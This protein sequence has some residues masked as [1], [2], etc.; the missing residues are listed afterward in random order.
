MTKRAAP[1]TG[2]DLPAKRARESNVEAQVP[3]PMSEMS[4]SKGDSVPTPGTIPLAE[5][6]EPSTDNP[7]A[8]PATS[9]TTPPPEGQVA[10]QD[11]TV[12]TEHPGQAYIDV[13]TVM[14]FDAT[15]LNSMDTAM[16]KTMVLSLTRKAAAVSAT[17]P[18]PV[19]NDSVP[20]SGQPTAATDKTVNVA[21]TSPAI[22][23][24]E[25]A[26]ISKTTGTENESASDKASVT[27]SLVALGVQAHRISRWSVKE[28]KRLHTLLLYADTNRNTFC[29]THTPNEKDWGVPAAFNDPSNALCKAGTST[30]LNLWVVGEIASMWW[31]N[32]EGYPAPHP[33]ISIQP[34]ADGTPDY[35]KTFL[36]ELCMPPHSSTSAESF[37][38]SQV[39]ASCW[40]N[41]KA[42]ANTPS[43]AFEFKAI[44]DARAALRHKKLL[45][46]LN[47]GQLKVRDFVVLEVNVTRYATKAEGEGDK[48]GKRR[49]MDR[50]QTYFDL[51]AV[52]KIKDALP[53]ET[54]VD[55]A[56]DFEI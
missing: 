34:M 33:G 38:A 32:N 15:T 36:H 16:L 47:V 18:A 7:L 31:Y 43:K 27:A 14:G 20:A 50:W 6:A 10:E 19:N 23:P 48:K 55:P 35:S 22:A 24:N 29:I 46:P 44:Y 41:S 45:T 30:V 9:N 49:K 25:S 8:V 21:S 26:M 5:Q 4:D 12:G 3:S 51:K 42:A 28:L 53:E 37:G 54:E 40:M 2:A 1:S 52:Y 13:L 11:A 17:S 56:A 39:E